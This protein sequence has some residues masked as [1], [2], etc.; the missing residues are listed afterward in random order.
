LWKRIGFAEIIFPMHGTYIQRM[1]P[2][3]AR[4]A[5]HIKPGGWIYMINFPAKPAFLVVEIII[6]DPC[7]TSILPYAVGTVFINNYGCIPS[8]VLLVLDS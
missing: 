1:I 2:Q 4:D 5:H 8:Y 6:G 7:A 3:L